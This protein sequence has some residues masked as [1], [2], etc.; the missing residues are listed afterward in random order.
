MPL[1]SNENNKNTRS[2]TYDNVY[3][4]VMMTESL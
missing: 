4:V 1:Y 2:N 3:G